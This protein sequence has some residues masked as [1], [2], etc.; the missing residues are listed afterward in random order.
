IVT[1]L[2]KQLP[3]EKEAL[4]DALTI[5]EDR[6]LGAVRRIF[7]VQQNTDSD[8]VDAIRD[9][10]N[11]LDSQQ[12]DAYARWQNNDSKPLI[13]HLKSIDSLRETFLTK[14]SKDYGMRPV[15]DWISDRM[16]EYIERLER[17]K[18]HIDAN[19]LKVESANVVFEGDYKR[20]D[21]GQVAFKDRIRLT[22]QHSNSGVKIYIAEGNADPT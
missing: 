9:W 12:R 16:N 7:E 14:I 20:E 22:F 2:E 3:F 6:I 1:T 15:Q 13:L 4:E 19:R 8:I 11:S 10:Y 5:V 18:K 17:G 21:G